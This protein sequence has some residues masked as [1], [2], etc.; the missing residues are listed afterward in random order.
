MQGE[1]EAVTT[2]LG[3]F[4]RNLHQ[5]QAINANYLTVAQIL[6]QFIHGLCSSIL[7]HVHPR[8][9]INLQAAITN[10]R[11]FEATELEANHTQAN[12]LSLLI[13]PDDIQ[14]NNLETNQQLTLT[15]NIPLATITENKSLDTIFSF[16]LEKL[17]TTL[18]FS[19]TALKEKPI[20]A[21]Y[22]DAKV[23]GHP[24]KIILDSRSAGS[25]ITK[26]LIDQLGHRVDQ[27]AG[28]KIITANRVT[29]TLISEIN[30]LPIEIN[31]IIISIKVLVIE[32]TQ[33]QVFVGNDW[34][35]KT[36]ALLDWNIQEL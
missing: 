30:D 11:D 17:S 16:E 35:F 25:I 33:Y 20:T 13:T 15:S 22:T 9:P 29:K 8:H 19:G 5:I 26:Q 4:H 21:M 27:T 2:Y 12:Y 31:S 28:A 32:A 3:R 14:P 34:L 24:I 1:T 7:Q 23:N 36:N 6:N 10:A 18:L